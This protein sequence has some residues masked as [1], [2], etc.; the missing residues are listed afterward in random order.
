MERDIWGMI[1]EKL[2]G[3][4]HD[5][6]ILCPSMKFSKKKKRKNTWILKCY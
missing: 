4:G 2:E 3:V 1:P 5:Y 6:I